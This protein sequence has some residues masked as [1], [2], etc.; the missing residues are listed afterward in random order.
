MNGSLAS[1]H[2]Q[3]LIA[4][5]VL[6]D[7]DPDEAAKFQQLLIDYPTIAQEV[8]RMQEVLELTDDVPEVQPP[9]HLRSKILAAQTSPPIRLPRRSFSWSRV[10]NVAAAIVIAALAINNYRLSQE[11]QMS[12]ME[13][14][15]L[16]TLVYS[17]QATAEGNAASATVKV[18]PNRLEAVLTVQNLPP[19]PPGKVYALWTVVSEDAPV[20]SDD[21]SAILTDVFNVDAQ[22]NA[23]QSMLVPKVYRSANLVSKIAVT[24]EDAAAPQNHRGKPVLITKL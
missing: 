17:L 3:L 6:G 14:Q 21:K 22:G 20:T 23:S 7:L 9:A 12:Q 8:D 18:D 24:I 5:Y 4:G 10:A 19:L 11:L 1:E 15:Q 16:A 2:I 13:T